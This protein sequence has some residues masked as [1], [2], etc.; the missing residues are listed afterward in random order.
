MEESEQKEYKAKAILKDETR[1]LTLKEYRMLKEHLSPEYN[2]ICD[3]LLHTGMRMPELRKFAENPD[4]YDGR[5]RCIELPRK[6]IR[7]EKTLFKYRQINL[8]I[9]G[10]KAVD[11]FQKLISANMRI[12]TRQSMIGVLCRAAVAAK[13]PD[14]DKGIQP[15]MFR[16]TLVSLLMKVYPERML[17]IANNMGHTLDVMQTYYVNLSMAPDDFTDAKKFLKGW[18]NTE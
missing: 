13:L 3:V 14:E 15:K 6:A 8:T 18:G 11:H 9:D 12:P 17:E 4:W 1:V 2:A 10:C 7:K 16:K 5:R